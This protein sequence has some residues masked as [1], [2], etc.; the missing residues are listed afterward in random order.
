M[1]AE[2]T[3]GIRIIKPIREHERGSVTRLVLTCIEDHLNSA[4]AHD[5]VLT[6]EVINA[7]QPQ[8]SL[9]RNRVWKALKYL[10]EQDS[11]RLVDAGNE[12]FVSITPKGER[13]LQGMRISELTP[14]TPKRWDGLWRLVMFDIPLAH[15]A[16]RIPM[17]QK[18]IDFGFEPYQKSV[19][20]HPHNYRNE[21]LQ[22]A[23][24]LGVRDFVRF[25]TARSISAEDEF[26]E[27]FD[28]M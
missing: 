10:E 18:L 13:T 7:F 22:V 15:E 26:K 1:Y 5:R 16:A 11:I 20:I 27:K 6:V 23:E 12:R 17:K 25:V 9:E 8:N 4:K 2:H 21:V 24:Y 28:L 19:F 14:R 3:M